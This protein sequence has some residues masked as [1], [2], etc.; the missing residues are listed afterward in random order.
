M[1]TGSVL[2][3]V[4][5]NV[6]GPGEVSAEQLDSMPESISKSLT[7]DCVDPT[8]NTAQDISADSK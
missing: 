4:M 5:S 1:V 3:K 8:V 2:V 6:A 7:N